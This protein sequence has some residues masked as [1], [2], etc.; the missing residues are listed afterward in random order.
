MDNPKFTFNKGSL[1]LVFYVDHASRDIHETGEEDG[2]H[3]KDMPVIVK[4]PV[5]YLRDWVDSYKIHHSMF[6]IELTT[7]GK[8]KLTKELDIL[9][10]AI[11]DVKEYVA[12]W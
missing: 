6:E 2:G 8:E 12:V 1:Y 11:I 5:K 7:K 3:Y 4:Q 10:F 9:S